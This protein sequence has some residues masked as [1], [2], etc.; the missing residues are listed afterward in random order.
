[1]ADILNQSKRKAL[2]NSV[3]SQWSLT[4]TGED[5]VLN[6]MTGKQE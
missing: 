3:N 2:L 4:I 5:F 1:M 6:T